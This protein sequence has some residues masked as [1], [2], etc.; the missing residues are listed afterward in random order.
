MSMV[1]FP[2]ATD[3]L[4]KKQAIFGFAHVTG[5]RRHTHGILMVCQ[6]QTGNGVLKEIGMKWMTK[7]VGALAALALVLQS[8]T[9]FAADDVA[10]QL[11]WTPGG[12]S[13]AYYLG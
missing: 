1:H 10:F 12:I 4:R 9:A 13:A 8:G 3:L 5:T 7:S 2:R 6:L 11:D